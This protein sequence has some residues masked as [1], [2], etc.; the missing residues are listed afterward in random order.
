LSGEIATLDDLLA[1]GK[2]VAL[3]FVDPECGPCAALLPEITPL[4]SEH[5]FVTIVLIS[6]GSSAENRERFGGHPHI[7]VLLQAKHEV[8][9]AYKVYGT[10][11]TVVVRPN[12]AIGSAAAMGAAAIM[13]LLSRTAAPVA[14]AAILVETS[15]NGL[16]R[17]TNIDAATRP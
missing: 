1:S 17:D 11:A 15:G 13:D 7:R 16:S 5:D 6:S 9:E 14:A 2:T 4:R 8:A 12:G 10:P 3:T